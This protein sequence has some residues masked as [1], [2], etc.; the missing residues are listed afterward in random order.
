MHLQRP[1][2]RPRI[3]K[4]H[5]FII[6]TNPNI[7]SGQFSGGGNYSSLCTKYTSFLGLL[8]SELHVLQ[9]ATRNPNHRR[10]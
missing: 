10:N 4:R 5:R 2:V 8:I 1:T 6:N 3:I 9:E 7:A